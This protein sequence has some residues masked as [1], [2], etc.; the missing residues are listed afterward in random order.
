MD[1]KK[2]LEEVMLKRIDPIVEETL[3]RFLGVKIN[4][5]NSDIST[6]LRKS[7]ILG[8][9]ID[10]NQTFRRAKNKFKKEYLQ[11][12]LNNKYGNISDVAKIAK[13][14]RRTIHRIIKKDKIDVDDIRKNMYK[15]GYLKEQEVSLMISEIFDTYKEVL[16][17][18]KMESIY[19]NVDLLT[20][21]ILKEIPEE[22][23]SLKDAIKDFEERFLRKALTEN[24]FDIK[25]V[26]MK[27]K[28][29]YETLLRKMKKYSL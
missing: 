28:I 25:L 26:S 17:P 29:R 9:G 18:T 11:K 8:F 12:L 16:H 3:H 27:L 6:K 13:V 7:I 5:L 10:T 24:N 2:N 20:K 14:N 21:D 22:P 4:E 1:E 15:P 23:I 19:K